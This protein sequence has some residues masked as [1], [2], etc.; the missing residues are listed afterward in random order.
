MA[1][2][3]LAASKRRVTRRRRSSFSFRKFKI[4]GNPPGNF[5][6]PRSGYTPRFYRGPCQPNETPRNVLKCMACRGKK[7][8]NYH[9]T[10][11]VIYD[12]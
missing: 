12:R 7:G 9:G 11:E 2:S 5:P 6:A 10:L 3:W 8:T 1:R 4:P